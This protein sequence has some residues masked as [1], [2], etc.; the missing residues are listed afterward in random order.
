MASITDDQLC[1]E[2]SRARLSRDARFDGLFFTAVITTGIYCRSICPATPPKE[3]NVEYHQSSISAQQAGFRP[4]LR[5]RPDSA[6]NSYAWIGTET[7]VK[8]AVR[9]IDNGALQEQSLEALATR[10]GVSSRHLRA[11]FQ[12]YLGTSPKNYA[13]HRQCLFAKQLLHQSDLSIADIAFASGF[14]SIRRFNEAMQQRLSLTPSQIRAKQ[15]SD[16]GDF[17]HLKVAFRP[18]MRWDK[19]IG[20]LK[21]R[22]IDGVEWVLDNRYGRTFE[23]AESRGFFEVWPDVHKNYLH[24]KLQISDIKHLSAVVQRVKVIFDLDAPMELI[25]QQLSNVVGES[26]NYQA[27]LRIPGVWAGFESGVRGILGQQV[28]VKQAHRLVATLV[29]ELGAPVGFA[30]GQAKFYFPTPEVIVDS[31][32]AFFRMP[33][34][35]KDTLRRLADYVL[36]V[37]EPDNYDDWLDIKGIGPWTV[38]YVK[39]RAGKDPDVWLSGDAGIK[40]ALKLFETELDIDAAKPYRSYLG[41]QLWNLLGSE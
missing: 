20:F 4:C 38:N 41:F 35:R 21:L 26:F 17:I 5:C 14:N 23:F 33:Q 31:E 1:R 12:Q 8:R 24:L 39:L 27:G 34:S 28:S 2:Y 9:L 11:L 7:T 13:L 25:D 15:A 30:H 16:S 37:E 18:P 10:L 19:I 32:L 40:N 29:E 36:S 6:P 3:T 22:V